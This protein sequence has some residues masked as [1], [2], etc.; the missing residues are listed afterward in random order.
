MESKIDLRMEE[1]MN[2]G[3]SLGAVRLTLL[4]ADSCKA[5]MENPDQRLKYWR[6][7]Q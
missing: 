4:H 6:R 5:P 1:Q 2:I 7:K 3:E